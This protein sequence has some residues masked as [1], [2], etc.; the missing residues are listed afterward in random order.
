M[1]RFEATINKLLRSADA[2]IELDANTTI[3]G[4]CQ[5]GTTGT[6]AATWAIC[7]VQKSGSTTTIM[8]ANGQRN[9]N[10]ILD[11]HSTYTYTFRKF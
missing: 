9:Y 5:P 6:N 1:E 7:R 2:I 4:Y 8:W 3:L 11:N 10:L